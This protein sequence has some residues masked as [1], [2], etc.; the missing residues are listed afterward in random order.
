MSVGVGQSVTASQIMD[1]VQASLQAELNKIG[2]MRDEVTTLEDKQFAYN[3]IDNVL[4]QMGSVLLT[5]TKEST[6][7][8]RVAS[9]SD[10]ALVTAT[11]G[12]SAAKTSFTFS[13][14]TQLATA[15][16]VSSS[17]ALGLDAGS[18]PFRLS[19]EDIN[20]VG[21]DYD[22]NI[23]IGTDNQGV[24]I[25]AGTMTINDVSIDIEDTDTMYT[26]L[27]KINS[28]GAGVV[29]TFDDANDLVRISG[30][31]VGADETITVDDGDTSFFTET[32]TAGAAPLTAGE[33]AEVDKNLDQVTV[34]GFGVITDGF[35]NINNFT[36]S[37][38]ESEDTLNEII[39][40][41]NNSNCGAVMFYDEDTDKVTITNQEEGV[42]L[43]LNN[44]TSNFF[45]ALDVID[46]TGDQDGDPGE[47]I[48]VGDKAQFI[49][50]GESIEKDSNTFE[51]GGVTFTLVGTT[52][53]ENPSAT[54]TV[55][56]NTDST[57]ETMQ[58]FA[59]QFNATM[60]I[61]ENQLN[62]DGGPL[63]R[64]SIIRRLRTK[65][66]TEVL[67]S[68]D[69]PG[70]FIN[71][72]DIGFSFERTDGVFTLSLDTDRLRTSLEK[73]ETSV[74]QLFAFNN[75][76]DGLFDDGGYAVT[77]RSSLQGYTR[78]VSGFFYQR[79]EDIDENIDRLE[80][81][82][83]GLE[84]DLIDKEERLFNQFALSVQALQDLMA[85]GQSIGQINNIVLSN[86]AGGF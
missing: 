12:S 8:S 45:N 80:L 24:A 50:N 37:I 41:V 61:I 27:T 55:T 77:T 17:G 66:R 10:P 82:I 25:T 52:N 20:G 11:A 48:Y 39:T 60:S 38:D 36:F 73:S 6:F 28:A 74:R 18:A 58:S 33:D 75:D 84:Q 43:I 62:E 86:L 14:I 72:A 2:G 9:T 85:Q 46:K 29:A 21:P 59:S 30:T 68:I 22:P 70:S 4:E 13:A 51:I 63:E 1:L 57:I 44:D 64:D 7:S 83:L 26:I 69:N 53:A 40:R 31:T 19:T 76:S 5:L 81:K 78:S 47:S 23:A 42:P 35:F 65:L 54:V 79:N 15:A 16:G 32:Y 56:A 71:L 67:T 49:L 34:S 3:N